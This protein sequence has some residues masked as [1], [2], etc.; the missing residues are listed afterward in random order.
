MTVELDDAYWDSLRQ[1]KF[2]PGWA[3][4]EPSLWPEP[5]RDWRVAQFRYSDA[6]RALDEATPFVSPELAERRNV[7][8]INPREGNTYATSR[9][10]VAAYQLVAPGERARSHRHTPNALRLVVDAPAGAYTVVNGARI[11]MAPGDVVLTP[12]WSWHGHANDAESGAYWIDFLDVPFVQNTGPMFFE[13]HPHTYEPVDR[14]EPSSPMRISPSVVLAQRGVSAVEPAVTEIA[15]GLLS[16]IGL[17]LLSIPRNGDLPA[18]R[19]TANNLYSLVS[20][21]CRVTIEAGEEQLTLER[22]DIL[23]VPSWFD[24]ALHADA[25]TV[26]LRVSDRPLLDQLGLLRETPMDVAR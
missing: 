13:G 18:R 19:S 4:P 20:G 23:V 17:H 5:R 9:N 3:K 7:I 10:L 21:E 12:K 24:H 25:D 15:A 8:C 6:R 22:G 11:D 26:L 1:C 2:G 14:L 16:T